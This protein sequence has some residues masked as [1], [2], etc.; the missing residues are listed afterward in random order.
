[1]T[2]WALSANHL[3]HA[4]EIWLVFIPGVSIALWWSMFL[5]Y[6]LWIAVEPSVRR[7]WP[8]LLISWGKL[9]DGR[10]RDP[11]VGRDLLVGATAGV[12]VWLILSYAVW[13]SDSLIPADLFQLDLVGARFSLGNMANNV[14]WSVIFPLVLTTG[15]LLFRILLRKRWLAGIAMVIF[16]SFPFGMTQPALA[17][18]VAAVVT[19]AI[20]LLVLVRF[21]FL[22]I[23]AL[24]LFGLSSYT[25]T[26]DA[27]KWYIGQSI[28]VISI[29]SAIA[30]YGFY[31]SLAGR[32]IL[33]EK[34]L[35]AGAES[36]T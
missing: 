15:L 28:V 16:F 1:M 30:V 20:C 12:A 6:V 33:S 32:S 25:L 7:L 18:K 26:L 10:F 11:M 27:S 31:V 9:L 8:E 3:P 21:G 22:A 17:T 5:G 4:A 14:T 29:L 13:S 23:G 24:N 34:F 2:F 36:T 19:S 35:V